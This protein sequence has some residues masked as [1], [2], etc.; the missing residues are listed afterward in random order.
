MALPGSNFH[1]L[2]QCKEIQG[3]ICVRFFKPNILNLRAA[4]K[5]LGFAVARSA[6]SKITP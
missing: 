2:P 1:N 6:A 5:Q 3:N 4:G